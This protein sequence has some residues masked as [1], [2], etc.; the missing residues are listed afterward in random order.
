MTMPTAASAITDDEHAC[1]L[2]AGCTFV[3][4]WAEWLNHAVSHPLP[5]P[6]DRAA[7]EPA[8]RTFIG[9]SE[10]AAVCGLNPYDSAL[11]VYA[12]KVLGQQ[13]RRANLEG[14]ATARLGHLLEPALLRDYEQ[15]HGV[16]IVRPA[17][18][19][20]PDYPW[21]GATPDGDSSTI[22]AAGE[23]AWKAAG[24]AQKQEFIKRFCTNE[25]IK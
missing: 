22:E 7:W 13:R 19:R 23:A 8:R 17:T 3:G 9:A 5:H 24:E 12:A 15:Q 25:E 18:R 20:H 2:G 21:A 14:R 11:D 1:T 10:I 16:T 6:D 4:S